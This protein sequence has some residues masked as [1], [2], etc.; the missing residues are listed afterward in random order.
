M[1]PA[2]MTR[3]IISGIESQGTRSVSAYEFVFARNGGVVRGVL[4]LTI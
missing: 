4:A 3:G 2:F 1:K